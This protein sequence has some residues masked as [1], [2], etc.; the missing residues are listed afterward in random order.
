[1]FKGS[2]LNKYSAEKNSQMRWN[3]IENVQCC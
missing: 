1:M 2:A 3:I